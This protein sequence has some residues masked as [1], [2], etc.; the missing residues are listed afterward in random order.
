MKIV[1]IGAGALGGLIGAHLTEIGE[2]VVL[3]EINQSRVKLLNEDGLYISQG[4][5]GERCVRVRAVPSLEGLAP[6]DLVF[7]SVK[8]YQTADVVRDAQ[9]II[10]PRTYVL[11]MQNG[12]GN[13]DV[14][15]EILGP[16][17]VLCGITYHS[18]PVPTACATGPASSRSRSRPRMAGSLPRS[19]RSA[20]C[21]ARP[22]WPPT[23]SSRSTT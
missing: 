3:V 18:I 17:R 1:V 10:G 16:E 12:I 21:S 8:S 7:V 6:A 19:R 11:S 23:S 4:S 2:D 9:P 5:E 20:R 13:T 15:A 14:M 22:A